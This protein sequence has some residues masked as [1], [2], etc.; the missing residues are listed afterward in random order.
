MLKIQDAR[1]A[2]EAGDKDVVP[3]L[4]FASQR[5]EL[6]FRN[7]AR[8]ADE[9]GYELRRI[10]VFNSFDGDAADELDTSQRYELLDRRS[11]RV[12]GSA[13]KVDLLLDVLK[14]DPRARTLP[15]AG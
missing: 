7:V 1:A 8:Y 10:E 3:V 5:E 2:I 12:L 14:R 4:S 6:S 13:T 11:S 9:L 15:P